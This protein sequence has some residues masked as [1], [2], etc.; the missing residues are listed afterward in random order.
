[1]NCEEAIT[2]Y[3]TVFNGAPHKKEESKIIS[4]KR[5]EE[6]MNTPGIEHMVGKIVTA[7]FL[8]HGQR[9]IALDGGPTFQFSEAVSFEISCV[10]QQEVDYFHEKLSADADAAQC[11]WVKDQFGVSW[12]IVPVQL[13]RLLGSKD[14]QKTN[15]VMNALLSMKKIDIAALELAYGDNNG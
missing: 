14:S 5:Y 10:D 4:I 8:L 12:Q 3:V 15:R 7:E 13:E 2:Y 6:G 1:M 11:G 9:Y